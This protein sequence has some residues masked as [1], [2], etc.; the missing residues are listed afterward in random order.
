MPTSES[1]FG[2]LGSVEKATGAIR[3]AI[4]D[5]AD[6]IITKSKAQ[7]DK[8]LNESKA[9]MERPGTDGQYLS[10]E[11]W[12]EHWNQNLGPDGKPLYA[13]G[14]DPD[15]VIL[16]ASHGNAIAHEKLRAYY[17]Q[18]REEIR[19]GFS[20]TKDAYIRYNNI[21]STDD[22]MTEIM[23]RPDLS[24]AQKETELNPLFGKMQ[25]LMVSPTDYQKWR[26]AKESI[27]VDGFLSAPGRA[28]L[29]QVTPENEEASLK[30]LEAAMAQAT[31]FRVGTRKVPI[32]QEVRDTY[33]DSFKTQISQ[34]ASQAWTQR[35]RIDSAM[36]EKFKNSVMLGKFQNLDELQSILDGVVRGDPIYAEYFKAGSGSTIAGTL[37]SQIATLKNARAFQASNDREKDI[38]T[39]KTD[40]YRNQYLKAAGDHDR[41]K[42]I[43]D[44]LAAGTSWAK[45]MDATL[46]ATLRDD[47]ANELSASE[48]AGYTKRSRE[49]QTAVSTYYATK[50]G[51][52]FDSIMAL[53]KLKTQLKLTDGAA[54][55]L[56]WYGSSAV[57]VLNF[58][59]N[60]ISELATAEAKLVA[61]SAPNKITTAEFWSTISAKIMSGESQD[62]VEAWMSQ[63][64][65]MP[66]FAEDHPKALEAVDKL[67]K[68]KL[69]K[70]PVVVDTIGKI[71]KFFGKNKEQAD[72]AKKR[73]LISLSNGLGGEV[74]NSQKIGE[75]YEGI[76]KPIV[77][78]S[79]AELVAFSTGTRPDVESGR[80]YSQKF[81]LYGGLESAASWAE[82]LGTKDVA[83]KY[84]APPPPPPPPRRTS[85]GSAQEPP[86]REW[87]A[88]RQRRPD[89]PCQ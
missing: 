80:K 20:N 77:A 54:N 72:L 89:R 18:R 6:A 59:D 46:R 42:S 85:Q 82:T 21:V 81:D 88:I 12:E 1:I 9:T 16:K 25:N 23:A 55:P 3:G 15:T 35:E 48:N 7:I 51:P 69:Q 19:S 78:Q 56:A 26:D 39:Q 62:K 50:V 13:I 70:D 31:E 2:F 52:A 43:R 8:M 33:L 75:L 36:T 58:V 32:S 57:Q 10:P 17:D 45:D 27:I 65:L 4:E 84:D 79:M 67:Y 86:C 38:L 64:S 40:Y 37:Q 5:Q 41:L 73:F 24:V 11:Q 44:E 29:N 61:S 14:S 76:V 49:E 87:R 66:E 71:E 60:R 28:I 83:K 68:G 47:I 22:A 63:Y 34:R 53:Q 74:M 30:A